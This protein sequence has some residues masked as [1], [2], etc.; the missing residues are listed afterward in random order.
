MTV[1]ICSF[2]VLALLVVSGQETAPDAIKLWTGDSTA[3]MA[4]ELKTEAAASP[5]HLATRKLA[6]FQKTICSCSP[7]EKPTA[8]PNGTKPRPIFSSSNPAP[9]TLL[10]GG[11]MVGAETTEPH[12]KR[13]GTIEDGVATSAHLETLSAFHPEPHINFCWMVRRN[14]LTL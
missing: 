6:D 12:E 13:K 10:V 11:N 4:Q 5:Q 14:S 1:K 7:T 3:H 2:L 9:A 8:W